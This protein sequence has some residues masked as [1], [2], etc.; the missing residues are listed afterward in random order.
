MISDNS[1]YYFQYDLDEL[2]RKDRDDV[3][4]P[5][6]PKNSKL[7]DKYS[8]SIRMPAPCRQTHAQHFICYARIN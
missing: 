6:M 7:L 4:K 3:I 1:K 8:M 5:K 2:C